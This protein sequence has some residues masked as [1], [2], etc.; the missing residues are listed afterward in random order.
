MRQ[1]ARF[2]QRD[3][4]R[5]VILVTTRFWGRPLKVS[6]A[7]MYCTSVTNFSYRAP[8]NKRSTV[9]ATAV[10]CGGETYAYVSS[11]IFADAC[12]TLSLTTFT[13]TPSARS[14]LICVWRSS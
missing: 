6:D 8:Q 10:C 11:V 1:A 5:A 12:A 4:V 14:M 9:S 7:R 13:G 3:E 2:C